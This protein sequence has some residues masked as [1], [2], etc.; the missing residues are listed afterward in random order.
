[1]IP[2]NHYRTN[3]MQ[4]I[5]A[6]I[7]IGQVMKLRRIEKMPVEVN[8]YPFLPYAE[9]ISNGTKIWTQNQNGLFE[10]CIVKSI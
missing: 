10:I 7:K 6:S 8:D 9:P 1:M 4:D 5:L 2:N 3:T